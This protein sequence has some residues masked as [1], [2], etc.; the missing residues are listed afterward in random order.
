LAQLLLRGGI[1]EVRTAIDRQNTLAKADN[2]P[3]VSAKLIESVAD[4]LLPL[5]RSA[6]WYDRAEA[7]RTQL[8]SLDLRDLRSVVVAADSGA[9]DDTA[10]SLAADLRSALSRRVEEEHTGWLAEIAELLADGRS[11]RALRLSSRPP[12]AGA[13]LPPD[14]AQRLAAAAS[15][16]LTSD[17]FADR[18]AVVV[19]AVAFSPV[20]L[21]VVPQGI[22]TKRSD[23]LT[24]TVTK[25]AGRVPQIAALFG[26]EPAAKPPPSPG[27]NRSRSTTSAPRPQP[28][29]VTTPG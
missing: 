27:G 26:I 1:A 22:P 8:D 7:A 28:G 20:R 6:E 16:S 23:E 19:E 14:M 25:L 13:P 2:L 17:T 29:T 21:H 5:L 24:T 15:S 11:I 9:K 12:K 18:Y 3:L 10:R 4:K